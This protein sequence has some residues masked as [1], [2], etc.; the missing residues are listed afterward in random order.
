MTADLLPGG[1]GESCVDG[2]GESAVREKKAQSCVI[3]G[4]VSVSTF[5][6]VQ[7]PSALVAHSLLS[8]LPV[9]P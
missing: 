9:F 2:T 4:L 6:R 7:R 1:P 8:F 3:A 5:A